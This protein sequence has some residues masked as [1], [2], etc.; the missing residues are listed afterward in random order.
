MRVLIV[1]N[2]FPPVVFG[3]YEILCA[4]VVDRLR[5]R[6]YHVD[7]ITSDFRAGQVR[8][9]PQVERS[10]RLTTDFPLPGEEVA[11]VDFR[12]GSIQAVAER[13]RRLLLRRLQEHRYDLVFCWCM[14]RLSLGPMHAAREMAVPVCYTV[15]DEHPRQFRTTPE[16][17]GLRARL[18]GLAESTIWPLATFKNLD[19]VPTAIISR[20]LKLSL[21]DQGTPL[22]HAEV[23]HQ[24]IPLDRFPHRPTVRRPS[25]SL[26]LLYVGQLSRLK[27]VHTLIRAASRLQERGRGNFSLT[28]VG[29]GV[30]D[31]ERELRRLVR[32][33]GVGQRVEFA[34]RRPHAEVA[35]AYRSHHVLVFPTEGFEGFGLTHMEAMA[36]GCAVVS[37]LNG[38]SGELIRHGQNALSYE[39]GDDRELA[40]RIELLADHEDLRRRLGLAGRAWVEQRHDLEGYV[41]SLEDF[42][43]RATGGQAS[44]I[45]LRGSRR[46][47]GSGATRGLTV[48]PVVGTLR[49]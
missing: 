26:R 39:A 21:L 47:F 23:I 35:E 18:R 38:G 32:E 25:E 1:S 19:G 40:D 22:D 48:E 2:L 46:C 41:S 17:R 20:A 11:R 6:G 10:L 8:A 29:S 37:T 14:N 9:D 7:V 12:L 13:N 5:A 3:G 34:G 28:I 24:G 44:G 43:A 30:P 33:G 31:Y 49:V 15:N 16:P 36:S 42:M 27:G 45:V 4:Q